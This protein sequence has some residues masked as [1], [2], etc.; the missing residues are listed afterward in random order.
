MSQRCL[1][2]TATESHSCFLRAQIRSNR[3]W[4]V[5][6]KEGCVPAVPQ[7]SRNEIYIIGATF[8]K[9]TWPQVLT[10][11][12]KPISWSMYAQDRFSDVWEDKFTVC[13]T[14][15]SARHNFS[16]LNIY[17]PLFSQKNPIEIT[18]LIC[19]GGLDLKAW[20]LL[21]CGREPEKIHAHTRRTCK[22]EK[23]PGLNQESN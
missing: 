9:Q 17:L 16:L 22:L 6:C 20:T 23:T 1:L 8:H 13:L 21:V 12:A 15:I 7:R 14:T 2:N 19:K 4:Q 11:H 3:L 10:N 5:L 18:S